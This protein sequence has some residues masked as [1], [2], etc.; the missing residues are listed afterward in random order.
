MREKLAGEHPERLPRH[1]RLVQLLQRD[2]TVLRDPSLGE[3][4][5]V[6]ELAHGPL[7]HHARSQPV[8]H[9]L[10]GLFP[11]EHR[12]VLVAGKIRVRSRV[13]QSHPSRKRAQDG[14]L[15][16]PPELR[17]VLAEQR[18]VTQETV[19][20]H[21]REEREELVSELTPGA[22]RRSG[23]QK[24]RHSKR[25]REVEHR[26]LRVRQHRPPYP[27]ALDDAF[28]V[29]AVHAQHVGA[30]EDV[31]DDVLLHVPFVVTDENRREP[32]RLRALLVQT[33]PNGPRLS[34]VLLPR[35]HAPLDLGDPAHDA[36]DALA[37]APPPH[38]IRLLSR[39]RPVGVVDVHGDH[40]EI[41]KRRRRGF[42]YRREDHRVDAAGE[43]YRDGSWPFFGDAF[44][45]Y[46]VLLDKFAAEKGLHRPVHRVG[47][48]GPQDFGLGLELVKL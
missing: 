33:V 24:V 35:R 8:A 6:D 11:E 26:I 18:Q 2:P 39:L 47:R 21:V 43:R 12:L 44:R 48:H 7:L 20:E 3:G 29:H 9:P 37:L 16:H 10:Q 32:V 45:V 13:G 40:V 27:N 19:A 38:E 36:D 46:V 41:A 15:H 42:Q 1:K 28:L 23:V 30:A 25:V 5:P 31:R 17:A 22:P 34:L 14:I 4:E